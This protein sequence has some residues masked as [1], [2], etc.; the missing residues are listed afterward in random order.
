MGLT[1][2]Q[3]LLYTTDATSCQQTSASDSQV[4]P[5]E[6]SSSFTLTAIIDTFSTYARLTILRDVECIF[7][8]ASKFYENRA[9]RY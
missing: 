8:A 4:A 2:Q 5:Q 3:L 6:V 9:T 7:T 1:E